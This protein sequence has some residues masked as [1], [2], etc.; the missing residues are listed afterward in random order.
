MSNE[1]EDT[2]VA[3]V[4]HMTFVMLM[5]RWSND[6]RIQTGVPYRR[7]ATEAAEAV[8]AA[9]RERQFPERFRSLRSQLTALQRERDSA[10]ETAKRELSEQMRAAMDKA[11]TPGNVLVAQHVYEA[12]VDRAKA[13]EREVERWRTPGRQRLWECD[14]VSYVAEALR[15]EGD[16]KEEAENWPLQNLLPKVADTWNRMTNAE[17]RNVTLNEAYSKTHQS[18][19]DAERRVKELEEALREIKGMV[20]GE[21]TPNWTLPPQ[22]TNQRLR[23]ADI[24]DAALSRSQ[25]RP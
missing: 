20:V 19:R 22:I 6:E 7:M 4:R 13:A 3:A 15:L 9:L 17:R 24:I 8:E 14:F 1:G 23:I 16:E 11:F 18:W 12:A 2:L 5:G 10:V 25:D 21:R